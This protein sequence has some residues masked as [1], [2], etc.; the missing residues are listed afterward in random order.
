MSYRLGALAPQR[1]YGLSELSVYAQGKLPTPPAHVDAPGVDPWQMFLNDTYVDCTVAGVAHA[2]LAWNA[3]VHESD[4]VPTDEQVKSTFFALTGGVD[5]GCVEADV[6]RTWYQ[7]GLF[8][9]K[10]AGYAPVNPRDVV[11]LHQA[12]AFYG[13]AYL[14]VALPQSAQEQFAH[15]YEWNVVPGSPIDGGHCILAV[16]YDDYG[17][18]C[19]TWGSTVLV[20]YPWLAAY[21]T[22]VWAIIGNQFVEAGHGPALDIKTLQA[23]LAAI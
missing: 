6:L 8:G 19:V 22:E 5:S 14:G 17:V 4:A 12:I 16:G 9:H 13:G 11:G 20:S 21:C 18:E 2:I 15:G 1:P 10:I 7:D 3:E 23:D